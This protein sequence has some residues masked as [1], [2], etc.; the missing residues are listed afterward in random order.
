[1][2]IKKIT[3]TSA[4]IAI[5]ILLP[6]IF[7]AYIPS[8]QLGPKL[9]PIHYASFF[10][11]GLFGPIIG[12]CVGIITP[13]I[14]FCLTGMPAFPLLLY[15]T[16]E[17]MVYGVTFGYLYFDKKINIYFSLIISMFIGRVANISSV[18]LIGSLMLG[19]GFVLLQ[20]LE[21]LSVSI[22][23]AILQIMVIPLIIKR[24]N[25]KFLFNTN[26]INYFDLLNPDKTCVLLNKD[27][28]I[29]ES[30][31]N[32]VK[33]FVKYIYYN[34]FPSKETILIDKIIGVA[35]ANIAIYCNLKTVYAKIIS[36][37]ALTLLENNNVTVFFGEVVENILKR[38]KLDLC[39]MEKKILTAKSPRE[40]YDF[41]K[42]I[43]IDE[44]PIHLS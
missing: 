26:T 29:Y 27:K 15:I 43:V 13:L 20:L 1:M 23:G 21:N 7:H 2:N 22:L 33:P 6:F 30:K 28:I 25:S 38:D 41:L 18:Y 37:P 3:Y 42:Q 4:I 36:K 44:D 39:P 34:G 35:I 11:G 19:K 16:I 40:A 12:L 9:L 8:L 10:A 24:L 17:I 32:S 31:E 14:S 5:G